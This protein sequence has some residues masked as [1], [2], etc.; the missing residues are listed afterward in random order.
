MPTPRNAVASMKPYN[1]PLEGRRDFTRMD[2]NENARG[3]S[4]RILKALRK[5]TVHD[6]ATYPEYDVLYRGLSKWLNLPKEN[7]VATNASDEGIMLVFQTFLDPGAEIVLPV[8]TFAMFAFYAELQDL[9]LKRVSYHD[10][11]GFPEEE[12]RA[13]VGPQTRALVLVNPNNP[14]GTAVRRE[15]IVEMLEKMA[16][17]LVIVDEAYVEFNRETVLDL[18]EKYDNLVVL[19]TFSKAFGMAGLRLGLVLSAAENVRHLKKAHSP[20]SIST[21]TVTLALAALADKKPVRD[22]IREVGKSKV[23]LVKAL[24]KMGVPVFPSCANF[25]LA[26]FGAECDRLQAGLRERGILVRN[27][28]NAPLLSG[29]LRITAGTVKNTK[30][31]VSALKELL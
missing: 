6:V 16:G 28:S 4:A 14:T 23:L 5:I 25:I 12:V 21:L 24:K 11:L 26:R 3:C 17:R 29:C 18:I 30:N 15:F 27:F 13:A 9:R 19:R 1:P 7:I 22:Y 8:P 10:D 31:L 20:Y 2:F